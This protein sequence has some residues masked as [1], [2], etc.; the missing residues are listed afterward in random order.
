[1][2]KVNKASTGGSATESTLEEDTPGMTLDRFEAML[3]RIMKTFTE[4]FNTCVEKLVAGLDAKLNQRLE[5]QSSEMFEL[6]KRMDKLDKD[7][8]GL[9]EENAALRES[10]KELVKQVDKLAA[11]N[12]DLD[13]Y[14]R[15]ENLLIHGVQRPADNSNEGDLTGVVLEVIRTNLPSVTIAK[16][17]ISTAH[18]TGPHQQVAQGLR[19]RPP[20]IVV[21]FSRRSIRNDVLNSRR[22]LKGKNLS[23][24]EQLTPARSQLLKKASELAANHKVESAWSRDGRIFVK[25]NIGRIIVIGC[26]LDLLQF[27]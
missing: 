22:Q 26:E 2:P 8:R 23:I 7:N 17:D 15:C 12:D 27:A 21:R 16:E 18:R 14:Q 5:V 6:S 4:T 25:T 9:Q 10:V 1:M 20:P 11:A 24:T 19:T 13:Q 3:S